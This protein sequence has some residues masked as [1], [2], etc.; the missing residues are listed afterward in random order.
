MLFTKYN[1]YGDDPDEVV[2]GYSFFGSVC[3]NCYKG[4]IIQTRDFMFT[5]LTATHELGHNLGAD[6]D[7]EGEGL[8]CK[9]DDYFLMS[10]LDPLFLESRNYSRNPWIFSNCSVESFKRALQ[11]KTCLTNVGAYY[12]SNEFWTFMQALPGQVISYNEQCEFALG[13]GSR[14]CGSVNN[15]IC[16]FMQCTNPITQTCFTFIRA[17]RGT[18]CGHNM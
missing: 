17:A 3:D 7:G 9:A 4:S 6:H 5:V 13:H 16:S 14:F 10:P 12:N 11:D 1:I 15:R 2:N 8:A 18:L